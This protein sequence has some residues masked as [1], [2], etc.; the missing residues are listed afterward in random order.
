MTWSRSIRDALGNIA[1]TPKQRAE[2]AASVVAGVLYFVGFVGFGVFPLTW[3]CFVPILWAIRDV[4]PGRA[5]FLGTV[6]GLVTNLGGYYWVVHLLQEFAFLPLPLA[7]LGWVLLSAYQGFLLAI[8]VWLVHRAKARLGLAPVWALPVVFP[9]MELAY[10]LLFPSYIG[11][12]QYQFTAI[13]QLV[14]LTGMLGLTALIAVVNGGLF[15]LLEAYGDKRAIV[16]PRLI[17]ALAT[18]AAALV[19]GLVR[20]PQV[21]AKIAAARKLDVGIVQTNLGAREKH[22]RA[23]E[24]IERHKT[25]SRDLVAKHPEVD[26]IV[27]PESAYNGWINRDAKSVRELVTEGI[28]RPLIFGALTWERADDG[29]RNI[30]NTAVLAGANGEILGLF[31]KIELL[32]FGE[33]IPFVETFPQLKQ[34][35]KY[36]G[37]FT[38]GKSFEPFRAPGATLLPM[39]CYED[40]IPSFVRGCGGT[41]AQPKRSSTSRTT[42][43]TA[44]PTSR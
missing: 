2:L 43:G 19:F 1:S 23:E 5:L 10:P 28:D 6:F 20:V 9:A 8:V 42:H 16:R 25:M 44:T 41:A 21:D 27:W 14:E 39:I 33:T 22:A 30:Y 36:S 4:S 12:S 3:I 15:E 26:L 40:I 34:L 31:D 13:T 38:R 7:M 37:V 32:A 18:F 17:T 35:F 29:G 11:N 24:F